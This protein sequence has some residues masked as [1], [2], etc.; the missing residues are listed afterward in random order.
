MALYDDDNLLLQTMREF[1]DARPEW[2][3][4]VAEDDGFGLPPQT[5]YHFVIWAEWRGLL[6]LEE[7]EGWLQDMGERIAIL[8]EV[9]RRIDMVDPC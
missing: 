5:F 8:D 7:A 9:H 2:Q 3:R 1:L 4:P 6:T